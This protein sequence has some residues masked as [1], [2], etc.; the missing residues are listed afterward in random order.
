MSPRPMDKALGYGVSGLIVGFGIWISVVG[1]GSASPL[2]WD[3]IALV[4]M[5]IGLASA[6][7]PK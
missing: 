1:Q 4:P 2:L 5:V 7:S 3:L 6:F